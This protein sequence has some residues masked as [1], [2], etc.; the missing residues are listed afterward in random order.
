M[1]NPLSQIY[2]FIA[3]IDSYGGGGYVY[4]IRGSSKKIR[5]DLKSLQQQRWINNHTRAVFLEFAVYNA[6]VNLFGIATIVAEF[7][8]GGGNLLHFYCNYYIF[9]AIIAFL[10]QLFVNIF[11]VMMLVF[12]MS[13]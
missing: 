13:I 3:G 5:Q 1:K 7:I 11:F 9:T 12:I 4:R 6:N 8:P 2:A 10:L